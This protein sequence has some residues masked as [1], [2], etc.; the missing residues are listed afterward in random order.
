MLLRSTS[1][2]EVGEYT[3]ASPM[4][5]A[6]RGRWG[7]ARQP[8]RRGRAP[9]MERLTFVA[10][11]H[12]V[13]GSSR[14]RLGEVELHTLIAAPRGAWVLQPALALV[15]NGFRLWPVTRPERVA[16]LVAG[17][18]RTLERG[19]GAL[20]LLHRWPDRACA[21]RTEPP[22]VCRTSSTS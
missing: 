22:R 19:L 2:S 5:W 12:V 16:K 11:D 1:M 18:T 20:P 6:R 21:A 10:T 3:G 15:D 8:C 13:R 7:H 17:L 4:V 9:S 14:F